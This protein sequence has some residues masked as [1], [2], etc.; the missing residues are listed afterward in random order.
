MSAFSSGL[1]SRLFSTTPLR[2]DEQKHEALLKEYGEVSNSFRALADIRFKLLALL[3]IVTAV[4]QGWKADDFGAQR[5][6]LSGFGLAITAGLYVYNL[7][8]DQ[9]YDFL[10]GRAA[11]IERTLGLPDGS[12]SNRPQSWLSPT[13]ARIPIK[14]DHRNAINFIYGTSA[15]LWL[16]GIFAPVLEFGRLAYVYTPL[17]RFEADP[18]PYVNLFG[19]LLAVYVAHRSV[20]SIN[21]QREDREREM[22][23]NAKTAVELVE[24]L[25]VKAA[26]SNSDLRKLCVKLSGYHCK[27]IEA[28]GKFYAK[29]DEESLA[30]YLPLYPERLRATHLIA[31]LTDLPPGLIFNWATGR[32]DEKKPD[33]REATSETLR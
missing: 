31:L 21:R 12:F 17:P 25:D 27:A 18:N 13:L 6:V 4:A 28:R 15:A 2:M 3:P 8:N 14:L 23:S 19:A 20:K 11:E 26:F 10:I 32:R 33:T 1:F 22:K 30:H 5:L 16:F 24:Q 29:L 7:R 9:F